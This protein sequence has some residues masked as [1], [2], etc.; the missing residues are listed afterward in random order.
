[1][2]GEAGLEPATL[3][4]GDRCSSRLSYSPVFYIM[5]PYVPKTATSSEYPLFYLFMNSMFSIEFTVLFHHNFIFVFLFI[6][7]G[8][9]ISSSA[10]CTLKCDYIPH[11]LNP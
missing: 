10:F 8:G 4:F 7:S 11:F 5:S 2:A 9:V 6:S 1:M 3:G